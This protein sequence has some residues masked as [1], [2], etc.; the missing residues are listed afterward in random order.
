MLVVEADKGGIRAGIGSG[1]RQI[2]PERG[3]ILVAAAAAI[4]PDAP[5]LTPLTLA[6]GQ[7]D[8]WRRTK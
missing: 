7:Q 3:Q 8:S 6:E 2:G 4:R 1:H 5:V